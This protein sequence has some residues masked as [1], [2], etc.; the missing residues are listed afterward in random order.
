MRKFSLR[1]VL[2]TP[3]KAALQLDFGQRLNFIRDEY[4]RPYRWAEADRR[5]VDRSLRSV[6]LHQP[7]KSWPYCACRSVCFPRRGQARCSP[8]WS[9][10]R[11]WFVGRL[12]RALAMPRISRR[13][14]RNIASAVDL[15]PLNPGPKAKPLQRGTCSLPDGQTLRFVV[16]DEKGASTPDGLFRVFAGLRS[17][18]FFLAWLVGPMKKI[19]NL[20]QHDNVLCIVIEFDTA[21][22]S[23]L[24]KAR[25]SRPLRRQPRYLGPVL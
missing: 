3:W 13:A 19:P 18:P 8:T 5:P 21:A 4:V 15:T 22:C 7:G 1:Q 25:C 23:I 6:R 16:N 9:I 20:L 12:W 2:I 14:T 17:D 10:T 11:L 24:A